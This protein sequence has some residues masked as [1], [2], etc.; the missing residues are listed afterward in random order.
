[1]RTYFSVHRFLL[2]VDFHIHPLPTDFWTRKHTKAGLAIMGI[3]HY[4]E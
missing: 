2:P 1:V 3:D 4:D